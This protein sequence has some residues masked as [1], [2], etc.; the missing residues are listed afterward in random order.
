MSSLRNTDML[1]SFASSCGN[2]RIRGRMSLEMG[3]SFTYSRE[4]KAQNGA[5]VMSYLDLMPR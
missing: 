2:I 4:R 3:F 5:S 1:H